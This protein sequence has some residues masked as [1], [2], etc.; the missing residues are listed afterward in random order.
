[1]D[2]VIGY[3][4]FSRY[5]V[6]I[7]YAAQVVNLYESKNYQYTGSGESVP[8]TI[9]SNLPFVMANVGVREGKSIEGGFLIDTGAGRFNLILNTPFV[10]TNRLLALTQKVIREPGAQGVGGE[11]KL[12][13]GRLNDLQLGHFKLTE[14]IVHFAQDQKGSLASSEF[15]GVIGGEFLR[16]FKVVFD[17]AH[18]RMI[19]EPNARFAERSEYDMSGIRLRT[20]G[21]DS[22]TFKVQRLVENSPATDAGL[23]EGD[24]ISAIDNKPA[25]EYS[26][27]Q[28]NQMFK[29][30]GK[31]YLLSITRGKEK[32]QIRI[33][34]RRLI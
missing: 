8:L 30:D 26:L 6:E 12:F 19:L 9:L 15:N 1:V 18:K 31:E 13:V 20:E 32:K 14:P 5:V 16:R 28:I 4:L 25:S 10:E 23:Q 33:K 11:T 22:K 21:E 7:D 27:S 3:K 2:G 34:L 29:Q 24:I 17:Y